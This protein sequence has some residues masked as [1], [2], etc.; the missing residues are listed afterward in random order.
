MLEQLRRNNTKSGA[1][2]QMLV[3]SEGL[4][5]WMGEFE[6]D[7]TASREAG[8]LVLRLLRLGPLG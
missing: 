3:D 5:D 6:V 2:E 4:N 7:L 1:V 8:Q